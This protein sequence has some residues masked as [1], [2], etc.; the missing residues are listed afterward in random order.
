LITEKKVGNGISLLIFAGIVS[1]L[2]GVIR[3]ALI[4]YNPTDL[5]TFIL[6]GVIALLTVVGVVFINE[7]QRNIPINYARQVRGNRMYGGNSSHLPMRVNMAGVIPIIFAISLILIPPML[8]QFFTHAKT[9]WIANFATFT[10]NVFNNQLIYGIL[11]FV[12]VFGFTYFYTAVIF[13]PQKIAEN[14]Q[15]QGGFILGIRPGKETEKYL[16]ITMNRI[17]LIGA[18]FLGLIAILPLLLQSVMGTRSLA[19]GGTSLLIVV[20]VAIETAKQIESQITMHEY[21]RI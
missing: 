17:N 12:F 1:G 20:A 21:D 6:F 4:N 10:I 5:Y 9:V 13:H 11:Y 8:A 7:G 19:I 14:L 15:R 18:S 3:N 16:H 2:P